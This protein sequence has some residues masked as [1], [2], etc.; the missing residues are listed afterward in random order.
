MKSIEVHRD[1]Y[2]DAPTQGRKHVPSF[3]GFCLMILLLSGCR[4]N[5]S[6]GNTRLIDEDSFQSMLKVAQHCRSGPNLEAMLQDLHWLSFAVYRI[7]AVHSRPSLL[8]EW[9]E[10]FV[11]QPT[12]RLSVDPGALVA[13]CAL[14]AGQVAQAEARSRVAEALYRFILSNLGDSSHGYYQSQAMEKIA[15][16]ESQAHLVLHEAEKAGHPSKL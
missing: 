10:S 2:S 6:F 1:W 5:G 12:I 3:I 8:P 4:Y 16:I 11:A 13:D 14:L 7:K 15:Q 9:T